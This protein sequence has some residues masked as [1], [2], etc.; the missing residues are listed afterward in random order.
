MLASLTAE[1]AGSVS[2]S[3]VAGLFSEAASVAAESQKDRR[4]SC[5]SLF[6]GLR[7]QMGLQLILA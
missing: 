4:F 5:G 1:L 6:T 7:L 2:V 3:V